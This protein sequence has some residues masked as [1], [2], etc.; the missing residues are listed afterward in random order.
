ME[1]EVQ[2]GNL[3]VV[4]LWEQHQYKA[5]GRQQRAYQVTGFEMQATGLTGLRK[6]EVEACVDEKGKWFHER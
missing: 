2:V 5:E 3:L 1:F 4:A 6:T